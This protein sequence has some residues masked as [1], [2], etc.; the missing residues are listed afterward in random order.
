MGNGPV[1][2]LDDANIIQTSYDTYFGCQRKLK[3]MYGP[4][5]YIG[6]VF[7]THFEL[8]YTFVGHKL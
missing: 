1:M 8:K 3:I 2:I 7:R 5:E 4:T 6:I